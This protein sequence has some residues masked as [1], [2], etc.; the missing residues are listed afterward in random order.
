VQTIQDKSPFINALGQPSTEGHRHVAEA[1]Q[2]R[3]VPVD[4]LL[5]DLREK[6]STTQDVWMDARDIRLDGEFRLEGMSLTPFAL[7]GLARYTDCPSVMLS[8][9]SEK[10]YSAQ[11]ADHLNREI[12]RLGSRK[13]L[14]RLISG[15]DGL[16]QVRAFCSDRYAILDNA[17]ALQMVIEAFPRGAL[18][19]I[20]TCHTDGDD[21]SF[22]TMLLAPDYIQSYPDS[23]Y[24]VGVSV[25]NSEVGRVP[26]GL[27]SMSFRAICQNGCVHGSS[28]HG[29]L[30]RKHQGRIDRDD[31]RSAI[32]QT[33]V[34][35][36]DHGRD[37][38]RA[39]Q[40]LK[41]VP[42]PLPNETITI[43]SR[44]NGLDRDEARNWLKG[45]Q[46]TLGEP[47]FNWEDTAFAL[48]QGLTRSARDAT[49][50]RRAN[51]ERIADRLI[52]PADMSGVSVINE[53]WRR[54]TERAES[55]E[56]KHVLAICN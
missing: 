39:V 21:D 27:D 12:S 42:V 47:S 30:S 44:E 29:S 32:R 20:L 13:F 54:I 34:D 11:A 48:V 23:D 41:T 31:L 4:L 37:A 8:Y 1:W 53:H 52:S 18:E 19:D 10:G 56:R 22:R 9:L 24:G 36:L 17:D 38:L 3:C 26:F 45:V 16:A 2:R 49:S 28:V 33:V 14:V 25:Q 43:L 7:S 35:A 50:L 15:Q 40:Y 51:L 55:V 46:M 5:R 6:A